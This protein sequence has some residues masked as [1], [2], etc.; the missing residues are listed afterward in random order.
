MIRVCFIDGTEE[1]V[2]SD[3]GTFYYRKDEELFEVL[4]NDSYV[5]FHANL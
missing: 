3:N 1:V 5:C 2:E 4:V